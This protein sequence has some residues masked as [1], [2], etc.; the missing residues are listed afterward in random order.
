MV[1]DGCMRPVASRL[2]LLAGGLGRLQHEIRV[3]RGFGFDVDL[4]SEEGFRQYDE[5]LIHSQSGSAERAVTES[6]RKGGWHA[7]HGLDAEAVITQQASQRAEG[8]G[9]G[10][11][12]I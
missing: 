4:I 2:C 12:D 1:V 10:G 3:G 7:A 5:R 9:S 6:S 8:E 11:G